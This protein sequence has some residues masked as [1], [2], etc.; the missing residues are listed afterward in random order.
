MG[1]WGHAGIYGVGRAARLFFDKEPSALSL[2]EAALLAGIIRAP[3]RYSPYAFPARA[4][5]RRNTVLELMRDEGKLDAPAVELA[6]KSEMAVV[7]LPPR[8]RLA[9]YFIDH[10]LETIRERYPV[11]LLAR[12]GYHISTTIDPHIQRVVEDRLAR[13]IEHL[14]RGAVPALQGAAVVC[15]PSTGEILAMAGGR[16]YAESQ[17]NRA[18]NITRHVGSLIKPVI[19]YTALRRGYTLASLVQDDPLSLEMGDGSPWRPENYDHMSHGEIMLVDALIHSYNLATVRL[20]RALG[21]GN[22]IFEM[23]QMLPS[24]A[25]ADNPSVLLGAVPCSPLD[26]AMLYCGLANGGCRV[27]PR[28]YSAIEN[29]HGTVVEQCAPSEPVRVWDASVVYLMN[30]ALKDVLVTGT[31]RAAHLYGMPANVCG[32]T[33]TT[34]EERDAW[35][36]GFTPELVVAVWIGNDEYLPVGLT[37]ATGALPVASMIMGAITRPGPV[38]PPDDIV[39]CAV[40]PANGKRASRWNS[41]RRT[42]PFIRGTEPTEVSREDLPGI[43]KFFRS[44]F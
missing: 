19:Y 20:G 40:D 27:R 5:A 36:V 9:P 17:F 35:F 4:L 8:Q 13:G 41:N 15:D 42:L 39:L 7:P 44:V 2:E 3:N 24:L 34:D 38:S 21:S 37:G 25:V 12:G 43:L 32:K 10:I 31:A 23:Q 18:T 30:A 6:L 26:V 22:V 1:Q 33:G 16:D 28:V 11:S 14:S 29:E